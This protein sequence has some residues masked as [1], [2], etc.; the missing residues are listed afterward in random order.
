MMTRNVK[1][2]AI[3][4]FIAIFAIGGVI[5]APT[6][7]HALA[8][9][10]Y[11]AGTY[12]TCTYNACGIT[13]GADAN[14]N[15]GVTPVAGSTTCSVDRAEVQVSTDSSTGY[16]LSMTDTD[17]STALTSSGGSIATTSGTSAAPTA[18]TAN[19]W[20]YRVDSINGFGAGP[21]SAVSNSTIPTLN[22]AAIPSSSATPDTI[23]T[24]TGPASPYISTY[25]WYG[26]C[27]NATPPSGAY[28]DSVTYTVVVN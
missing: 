8:G 10:A 21:T 14:V 4:L 12:G 1:R 9:S 22:F 19:K 3:Q 17:T 26:L 7:V 5:V 13:F 20:G 24:T 6:F 27:A 16:T 2:A 15:I 25:V 11:S 23:A 28:T 18:L